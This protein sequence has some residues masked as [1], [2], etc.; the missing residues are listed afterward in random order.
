MHHNLLR[1]K[2]FDILHAASV[3]ARKQPKRADRA[4]HRGAVRVH[5]REVETA[6]HSH[7]EERGVYKLAVRQTERNVR[8]TKHVFQPELLVNHTDCLERFGS[9]VLLGGSGKREAVDVDI[10]LRDTVKLRA[11]QD[12]LRDFKAFLGSFRDSVL[13]ERQ[14]DYSRAV[15]LNERQNSIKFLVLTVDGVYDR[16]ARN[17]SQSGFEDIELGCIDLQR[18]V[19]NGLNCVN[20]REHHFLFIDIGQPNVHVKNFGAAVALLDSLPH[21]IIKVAALERFLEELFARGIYAFA[22]NP[23]GVNFN[24]L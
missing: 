10:A 15:F 23:H 12:F 8:H 16:F 5:N 6:L 11:L 7:C 1:A 22:D 19:G 24:N 3:V 21:C 18:S 17:R 9:A 13:V 20:S 14:T 4:C 2:P